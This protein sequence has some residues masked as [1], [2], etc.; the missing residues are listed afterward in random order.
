MGDG[1]EMA[2]TINEF[3]L[4]F[5]IGAVGVGEFI[6]KCAQCCCNGN[7]LCAF[8]FD[9]S[10]ISMFM[11]PF[12]RHLPLLTALSYLSTTVAFFVDSVLG[13]RTKYLGEAELLR[14][15]DTH[16]EMANRQG[17]HP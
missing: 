9:G 10:L 11:I 4:L 17:Q 7:L 15:E 12:F 2:E 3:G 5:V 8:L 1:K 6:L 14:E 16:V 13:V